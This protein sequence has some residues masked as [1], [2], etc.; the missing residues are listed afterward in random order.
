MPLDNRDY[1]R[2]DYRQPSRRPSFRFDLGSGLNPLWTIM[3]LNGVFFLATAFSPETRELLGF[4]PAL[5]MER[6]WTILT[7]LFVHADIWH[8]VFNMIAL[9]FFGRTMV[10]LTSM[11]K[12]L[13]VYFLGGLAGC[14]LFW[15]LNLDRNVLL[16]GASGAVYAICGALVVLVPKM[17]VNFWGIIPMPLWVFVI[18]FM[19]LFSVPPFAPFGIAWQAHIGGLATGAVFGYLFKKQGKAY[20]H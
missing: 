4:A 13:L 18:I 12:F 19:V 5:F 10:V 16:I 14:I 20:R 11:N 17:T 3:A 6:P 15:L 7:N 8:L 1:L 2:R 9:L